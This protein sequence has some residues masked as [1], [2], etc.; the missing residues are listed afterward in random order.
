LDWIARVSLFLLLFGKEIKY[1]LSLRL[2]GHALKKAMI[3]RDV[4]GSDELIH[5]DLYRDLSRTDC[6]RQ[7]GQSEQF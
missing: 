7:G 6:D 4:L 1:F 2:L 3:A 5:I